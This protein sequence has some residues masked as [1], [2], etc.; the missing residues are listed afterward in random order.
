MR[1]AP[2][3]AALRDNDVPQRQAQAAIQDAW[4]AW[5][6]EA[7]VSPALAE[8][9]HFGRGA[10]LEDCPALER[11][12]SAPAVAERLIADLSRKFCATL[13]RHPLAQPP[14]RH[15]FNGASSTMMIART[16]RAQL[17]LQACEPGS[18]AY[19]GTSFSD[20][21]RYDAVIGGAARGV[22]ARIRGP[23]E[24][25]R[26]VDEAIDLR[27]GTR[28]AFHSASETLLVTQVERRLVSL[29][30][31]R[32]F[33]DPGPNREYC[34]ES[35]RLLHQ[36]AGSLATSRKEMMVALLGRMGRADAAPAMAA[37]ARA[38]GDDSLRWQALRECL[39]LD[40]GPGFAALSHIARD[41]HDPLADPAG[42]LRAKLVE[43]HPQ[44]A[45]LETN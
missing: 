3:I 38:P 9:E 36:A 45:Q 44:L 28:L 24:Q 37:L 19:G 12:F 14:F 22:I 25:V 2:A 31:V 10:R 40:S 21:L 1:V 39:A 35:G 32:T 20:G 7:S 15:G 34:R 4:D 43:A 8:L 29:R 11:I 5:R 13:A 6:G 17:L 26:F 30:L 42:A 16:G 27:P 23:H 33:A 18:Y 41:V